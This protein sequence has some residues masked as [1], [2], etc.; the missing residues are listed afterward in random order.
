MLCTELLNCTL[1]TRCEERHQPGKRTGELGHSSQN[2]MLRGGGGEGCRER[3]APRAAASTRGARG[4]EDGPGGKVGGSLHPRG[5]DGPP[6]GTLRV[7]GAFKGQP[8]RRP[9]RAVSGK[10]DTDAA[11]SGRDWFPSRLHGL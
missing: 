2:E 7:Q 10:A 3:E 4:D 9:C 8:K 11:V 5:Q 6:G 1:K